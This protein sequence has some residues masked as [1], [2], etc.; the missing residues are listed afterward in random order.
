[1]RVSIQSSLLCHPSWAPQ[2][3]SWLPQFGVSRPSLE[4]AAC[5]QYTP[6]VYIDPKV[7]PPLPK[8]DMTKH[9]KKHKTSQTN[10]IATISK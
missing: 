10:I 2:S 7:Q 3:R 8:Q 5:V 1:M 6:M 4:F 9:P